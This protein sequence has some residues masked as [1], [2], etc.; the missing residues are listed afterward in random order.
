M[1]EV[2][3]NAVVFILGS[4]R[5]I[6]QLNHLLKSNSQW[7]YKKIKPIIRLSKLT[8]GLLSFGNIARRVAEKLRGF[9]LN[10]IT[11]L[12]PKKYLK[13]PYFKNSTNNIK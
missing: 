4:Q 13:Y 11:W 9:N 6:F 8:I 7:S 1:E 2:S 5:K 3:D 12:L 10:I